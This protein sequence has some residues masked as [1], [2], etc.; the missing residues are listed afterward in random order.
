MTI[1]TGVNKQLRYKVES[2][3]GTAPGVGSAQL[4]RRVTS[5]LALKKQAYES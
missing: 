4:L 5:D 1:A 2:A 3:W